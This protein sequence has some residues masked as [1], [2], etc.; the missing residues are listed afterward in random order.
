MPVLWPSMANVVPS[1]KKRLQEH[2]KQYYPGASFTFLTFLGST[3]DNQRSY[4]TSNKYAA[5][6]VTCSGQGRRRDYA[7]VGASTGSMNV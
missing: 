1:E 7:W 6:H 5:L 4:E 2:A 3:H